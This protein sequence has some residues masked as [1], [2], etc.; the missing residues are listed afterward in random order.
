MNGR[1]F[2]LRGNWAAA[3]IEISTLLEASEVDVETT[4]GAAVL[5]ETS[6]AMVGA[7]IS[8]SLERDCSDTMLN[9]H[10]LQKLNRVCA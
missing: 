8:C 5:S 6:S 3:L 10:L 9:N 7:W 2:S 1:E 4:K